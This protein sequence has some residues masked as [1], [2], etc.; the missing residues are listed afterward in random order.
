M[1]EGVRGEGRA[2]GGGRCLAY[3]IIV[4]TGWGVVNEN[5]LS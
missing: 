2:F 4:G 1:G 5:V 3:S